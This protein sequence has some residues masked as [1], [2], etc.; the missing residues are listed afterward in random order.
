MPYTAQPQSLY[1]NVGGPRPPTT[2]IDIAG[3]LDALGQST[4]SIIHATMLRKQAEN[5][6]QRQAMLDAINAQDRQYQRSRD[7]VADQ[8]HATEQAFKVKTADQAHEL[9]MRELGITPAH[10]E[11]QPTVD[12]V[13]T[14]EQTPITP[15]NPLPPIHQAMSGGDAMPPVAITPAGA[16][17]AAQSQQPAQLV[18][19]AMPVI[20]PATTP[21][22]RPTAGNKLLHVPESYNYDDSLAGRA[23]LQDRERK[24][25]DYVGA[26]L[27]PEQAR[28]AVDDPSIAGNLLGATPH[29]A[30]VQ[31][32][33]GVWHVLDLKTG[34]S[35]PVTGPDGKPLV[36][37]EPADHFVF[38]T[39][40]DASGNPVVLRGNTKT[41]ALGQTGQAAKP[42]G[43]ASAGLTE[44]RL[45][46]ATN[47]A[48]SANTTMTQ[49]ENEMLADKRTI[50]ASSSALAKIALTGG[51]TASSVA[52]AT[53][54]RMDPKVAEYVRAA[55]AI[56]V[57]ERL[58]SPR[59]GSN[60]MA[61]A[62]G[63]LSGVGPA[64]TPG[65]IQQA[66]AYR[67]ALVSGL[68]KPGASGTAAV[69]GPASAPASAPAT[70][71]TPPSS[72]GAVTDTMSD[73]FSK[74]GLKRV[75][76]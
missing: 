65:L 9:K 16:S 40:T 42:V 43:G 54:N 56:S 6:R 32:K 62:E 45:K 48:Q 36:G 18:R 2:Q 44:A 5:A 63:V 27:S 49:F 11:T 55:K 10:T 72:S 76:P 38:P 34:K 15:L 74:Y 51:P 58:I 66:R 17:D 47:Q 61:H 75:K 30:H 73:P 57:A 12:M 60:A 28:V 52:E 71:Q 35:T 31:G 68:S 64:A 22:Y 33:D 21:T 14:G 8:H 67:G 24:V 46:T 69:A 26:G 20:A 1:G 7:A 37:K 25:G 29:V 41:G 70:A 13:P 4:G 23:K 59:G 39:G 53:L 3:A 50:S 19:P